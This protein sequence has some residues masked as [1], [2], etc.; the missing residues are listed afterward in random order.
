[1]RGVPV[2]SPPPR[3]GQGGRGYD[4]RFW[5]IVHEPGLVPVRKGPWLNTGM[6]PVLRDFI[7][8]YPTAYLHVLTIGPDGTPYVDHGPEQLQML[9]GRSMSVGRKHNARTLAAHKGQPA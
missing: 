2:T 1:M 9:D 4:N 7:A 5:L 3:V 6:A 8:A